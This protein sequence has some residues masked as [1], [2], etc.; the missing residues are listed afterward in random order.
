MYII[1]VYSIY[2]P[3]YVRDDAFSFAVSLSRRNG[4]KDRKKLFFFFLFFFFSIT[5]CNAHGRPAVQSEKRVNA[6]LFG[7]GEGRG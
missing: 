4:Y 2:V 6:P 5:H 3:A 1:Y 7:G